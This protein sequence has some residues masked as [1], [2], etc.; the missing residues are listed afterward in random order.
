MVKALGYD[1][2][3]EGPKFNTTCGQIV[4]MISS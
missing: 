2:E 3:G 4:I 1:Q